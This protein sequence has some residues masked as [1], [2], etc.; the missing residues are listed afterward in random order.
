MGPGPSDVYPEVLEA[1]G[2]PTVGH[3][4]PYFI[5]LMDETKELLK[6][7]FRTKNQLTMPVSAPGSAGMETC[8]MNL[9]EPGDTCVVC[10]NGVFG[11]RMRDIVERIGGTAVV[12]EDDWGKPVDVQKVEDALK[13]HSDAKYVAFVHA[14]TS[15][16]ARSDAREL[17]ALAHTYDCLA[18]VDA[19]TSLGGIELQVDEWEIDAIYSGSQKCL[20][21][22][23]GISPVSFSERALE[24]VQK[25]SSKVKS[26]FL[27][28]NLVTQ[29]WGSGKSRSYHHTAPV[30]S[31][32]ALN[33][34]L[35]I[36]KA[37]GIENAWKRHHENHLKLKDGLEELGLEF[38][39]EESHR[40]PQLNA[41]RPPDGIDEAAVRR[42]LLDEHNIE[43]GAGL[44]ALAGKT[45][46]I[47]L[48]GYASRQENID[49][50]LKAL[51]Q[52][53]STRQATAG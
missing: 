11:G 36:L 22:I 18:I 1:L 47:G 53:L 19:V 38:A 27:D 13:Q 45:W 5:D 37:E 35:R 43:I 40:L 33:Q 26:W 34:S 52:V 24:V 42:Q 2:R 32:Y 46:R 9:I 7:A 25:R 23:P 48:M 8:L 29:Y 50:L 3:L 12:V 39:V 15:T 49:K 30:N 21:C 14:E 6:Y 31:I 41:V 17:V 51:R 10:V 28:V 44:G 16:G 4:D 20:S